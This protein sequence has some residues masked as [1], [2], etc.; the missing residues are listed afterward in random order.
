MLRLVGTASRV[1][2]VNVLLTMEV[3]TSTIGDCPLT[4]TRSSNEPTFRT[5]STRALNPTASVNPLR[6]SVR[7]PEREYSMRYTPAGRLPIR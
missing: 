2:R 6:T 4:S 5:K 1:E 7:K 3:E